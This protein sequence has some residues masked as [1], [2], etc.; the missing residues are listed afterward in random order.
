ML[1]E[2]MSAFESKNFAEPEIVSWAEIRWKSVLV[3]SFEAKAS[4]G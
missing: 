3:K 4:P 1:L 2:D